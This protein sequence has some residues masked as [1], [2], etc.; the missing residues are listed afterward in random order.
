M[1]SKRLLNGSGRLYLR[2]CSAPF[3]RVGSVFRIPHLGETFISGERPDPDE[4]A[5][6]NGFGY[7]YNG[8]YVFRRV[9]R[10]WIMISDDR[11]ARIVEEA[12]ESWKNGL[13]LSFNDLQGLTY[14]DGPLIAVAYSTGILGEQEFR[15][16]PEKFPRVRIWEGWF[17]DNLFEYMVYRDGLA[18]YEVFSQELPH[19]MTAYRLHR[20]VLRAK[21]NSERIE[22]ENVVVEDSS[23]VEIAEFCDSSTSI[24]E[25]LKECGSLYEEEVAWGIAVL[26]G[27]G[28]LDLSFSRQS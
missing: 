9:D 12:V 3:Y 5:F 7:R 6:P 20:P 17:E 23:L 13:E 28:C 25:I 26:V 18:V 27:L 14:A 11:L 10:V 19:V 22:T 1:I 16:E 21:L 24:G 8:S 2:K 4:P 15:T